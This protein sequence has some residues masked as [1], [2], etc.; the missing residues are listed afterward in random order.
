MWNGESCAFWIST[1]HSDCVTNTGWWFRTC[2][3]F[4]HIVGMS[5]QPHW[6]TPSFFKM[7][8]FNHQPEHSDP[9]NYPDNYGPNQDCAIQALWLGADRE[10][11]P[12]LTKCGNSH[13][14]NGPPT[15]MVVSKK[16]RSQKFDETHWPLGCC[17]MANFLGEPSPWF[18]YP[19]L[20]D[21]LC[22][23]VSPGLQPGEPEYHGGEIFHRDALRRTWAVFSNGYSSGVFWTVHPKNLLQ[24]L[25][26][27]VFTIHPKFFSIAICAHFFSIAKRFFQ[28]TR[29]AAGSEDQIL[30]CTDGHTSDLEGVSSKLHWF[31]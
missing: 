15:K 28:E 14:Q 27:L 8:I 16:Q 26:T 7:V 23:C 20:G 21:P 9:R 29:I 6:R 17:K 19:V 13:W 4:H 25:D 5:S 31:W 24:N 11:G 30:W 3:I 1:S 18:R 10:R 12:H 22:V 2:F